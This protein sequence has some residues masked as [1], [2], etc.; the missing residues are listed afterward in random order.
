MRRYSS[1]NWRNVTS[2]P[3]SISSL[4]NSVTRALISAAYPSWSRTSILAI[5]KYEL[6]KVTSRYRTFI[7]YRCHCRIDEAPKCTDVM[8]AKH[9]HNWSSQYAETMFS[10]VGALDIRCFRLRAQNAQNLVQ[11]RQAGMSLALGVHE[12]AA[13]AMLPRHTRQ[14]Q[15][16]GAIA[17][18]TAHLVVGHQY[19]IERQPPAIARVMTARAAAAPKAGGGQSHRARRACDIHHRCAVSGAEQ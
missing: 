6:S 1:G 9:A 3:S 7:R 16:A 14:L 17:D 4:L 13:D 12:Q 8:S 10:L 2:G 19:F 11:G 5:A 18:E 15:Y